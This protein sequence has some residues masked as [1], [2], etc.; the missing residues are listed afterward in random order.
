MHREPAIDSRRHLRADAVMFRRASFGDDALLQRRR[1]I[2]AALRVVD[3]ERL[4]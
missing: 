4:T 1:L 2:L 3:Q